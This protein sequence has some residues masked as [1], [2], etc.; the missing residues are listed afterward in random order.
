[1][2]RAVTTRSATACR[3]A[4]T[5]SGHVAGSMS[6]SA[7]GGSAGSASCAATP[8]SRIR[9]SS[10]TASVPKRS[11]GAT[12]VSTPAGRAMGTTSTTSG[13]SEGAVVTGTSGLVHGSGESSAGSAMYSSAAS[14][15]GRAACSGL[16]PDGRKVARVG[17][18]ILATRSAWPKPERRSA[19]SRIRGLSSPAWPRVRSRT[20]VPISSIAAS[21]PGAVRSAWRRL[22][23]SSWWARPRC[24]TSSRG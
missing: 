20:T 13:L 9:Q 16:T 1:M 18:T 15:R 6:R 5:K 14:W 3:P 7:A 19:S 4:S 2:G 22:P 21:L 8:K 11:P 24:L 10:M 17:V 12:R 23:I